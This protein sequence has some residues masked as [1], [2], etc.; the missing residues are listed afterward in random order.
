[1]YKFFIFNVLIFLY[2]QPK[3]F[4]S[5]KSITDVNL[6]ITIKCFNYLNGNKN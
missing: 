5:T 3:S 1:M 6:F 4:G 2:E